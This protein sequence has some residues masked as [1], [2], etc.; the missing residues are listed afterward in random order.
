[1]LESMHHKQLEYFL[2]LAGQFWP[3]RNAAIS[4][5]RLSHAQQLEQLLDADYLLETIVKWR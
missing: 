5:H 1:M 4:V 2:A 3:C